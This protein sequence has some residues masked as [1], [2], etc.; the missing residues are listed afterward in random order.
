MHTAWL[1]VR[2]GRDLQDG[3]RRRL[4]TDFTRESQVETEVGPSLSASFGGSGLGVS[5]NLA[6][7]TVKAYEQTRQPQRDTRTSPNAKA[8]DLPR[9]WSDRL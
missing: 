1:Q 3:G 6:S 4:V 9:N 2:C 5:V 7:V 8:T